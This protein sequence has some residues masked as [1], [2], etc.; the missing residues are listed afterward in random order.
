MLRI[1]HPHGDDRDHDSHYRSAIALTCRLTTQDP[2]LNTV[3]EHPLTMDEFEN[4]L[5]RRVCKTNDD[6]ICAGWN[7]HL[8]FSS[9][10]VP[11]HLF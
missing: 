6:P 8:N 10:Q 9:A 3:E 1:A 5:N 4:F 2:K 7:V 11:D